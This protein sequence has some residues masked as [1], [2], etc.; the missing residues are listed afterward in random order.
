MNLITCR[1]NCIYQKRGSCTLSGIAY[2]S[3]GKVA[4]CCYCKRRSDDSDPQEND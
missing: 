2:P 1:E 4:G 3:G